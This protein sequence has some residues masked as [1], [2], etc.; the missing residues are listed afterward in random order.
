MEKR[1]TLATLLQTGLTRI[2]LDASYPGV[3]VPATYQS[4]PGLVLSLSWG[5]KLPMSI[6]V[7]AV[8]ANLSFG[9]QAFDVIV[10]WGAIWAVSK[11][12]ASRTFIPWVEDMPAV[13][14]MSFQAKAKEEER[15]EQE[16]AD[17]KKAKRAHLKL[18]N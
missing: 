13:L 15:L 12:D 14:K 17:L 1:D 9:G 18:V 16:N 11:I 6:D 5:F 10:P 7:D 3:L 8:R 4:D 2:H